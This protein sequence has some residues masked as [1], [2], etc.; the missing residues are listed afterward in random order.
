MK[1][2]HDDRAYHV[3]AHAARLAASEELN[4]VADY[5]RETDR[6]QEKL[7]YPY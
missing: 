5:H 4:H 1:W 6:D 3:L 7:E 2:A